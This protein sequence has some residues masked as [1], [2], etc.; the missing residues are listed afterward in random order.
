MSFGADF[1]RGLELPTEENKNWLWAVV[2]SSVLALPVAIIGMI[3]GDV[4]FWFKVMLTSIFLIVVCMPLALALDG[5]R[6]RIRD[7]GDKWTHVAATIRFDALRGVGLGNKPPD[8]GNTWDF[9]GV[10]KSGSSFDAP[11][12]SEGSLQHQIWTN[13]KQS[14]LAAYTAMIWGD[15][16]SYT[17]VVEIVAYL[18]RITKGWMIRQGIAEIQVERDN[19]IVRYEANRDHPGEDGTWVKVESK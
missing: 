14:H 6:A 18:E 16:R 3:W 4:V 5:A 9:D 12:G 13:P 17:D 2:I 11:A 1:R 8:L 10:T 19:I 15:L 7:K